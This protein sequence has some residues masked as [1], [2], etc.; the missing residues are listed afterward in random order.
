MKQPASQ[1]LLPGIIYFIG[2][3]P[4]SVMATVRA[5]GLR[6]NRSVLFG[7]LALGVFSFFPGLSNV[8][9]Q[10]DVSYIWDCDI[11]PDPSCI[12]WPE[13]NDMAVDAT[14]EALKNN[15]YMKIALPASELSPDLLEKFNQL[16]MTD[17][18]MDC[19][20]LFKREDDSTAVVCPTA[21][22]VREEIEEIIEEAEASVTREASSYFSRTVVNR[23]RTLR[24]AA[25]SGFSPSTT[26]QTTSQDAV[27][28]LNAGDNTATRLIDNVAIDLGGSGTRSRGRF[29]NAS[30]YMLAT[31]DRVL[32]TQSVLGLGLGVEHSWGEY[33][34]AELDRESTGL[35]LTAYG[36]R[37]LN[38]NFLVLPHA[39]VT[40]LRKRTEQ[41]QIKQRADAWRAMGSLALLGQH[42]MDTVNLSGVGQFVYTHDTYGDASVMTGAGDDLYVG[43]GV[44]SGEVAFVADKRIHPFLGVTGSY[45]LVRSTS[46]GERFGYEISAGLRSTSASGPAMAALISYGRRDDE[47]T[48]SGSLFLKFSW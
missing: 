26:P 18:L 6:C 25:K 31:T 36:A 17:D 11:E 13:K 4:R 21:V 9:A 1:N 28:G 48:K 24:A 32:N 38:K 42:A 41:A 16:N 3:A 7:M 37:I 14:V 15:G 10:E 39:A 12:E 22:A 2:Q 19:V 34:V 46:T 23:V 20:L 35:T 40:Y 33:Q 29:D 8:Q 5:W 45:D 27:T 47:K 43:Q 44:L 30:V